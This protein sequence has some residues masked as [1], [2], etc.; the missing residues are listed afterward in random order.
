M[1]QG[2]FSASM[3]SDALNQGTLV[4]LKDYRGSIFM[5]APLRMI[6]GDA[7]IQTRGGALETYSEMLLANTPSHD[8]RISAPTL[9]QPWNSMLGLLG[10]LGMGPI[11]LVSLQQPQDAE[12]YVRGVLID[13]SPVDR[14]LGAPAQGARYITGCDSFPYPLL[15]RLSPRS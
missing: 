11:C 14:T 10:R 9:E 5:G 15:S 13:A 12:P 1:A 4:Q 8:F 7:Q 3:V 6:S 2:I